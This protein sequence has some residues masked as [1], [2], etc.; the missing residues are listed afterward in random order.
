MKLWKLERE[1]LFR[2]EASLRSQIRKL[3]VDAL[4]IAGNPDP[5]EVGRRAVKVYDKRSTLV[6]QGVLNTDGAN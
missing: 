3:V 1:L 4:V 6:H 2:R 5:Q